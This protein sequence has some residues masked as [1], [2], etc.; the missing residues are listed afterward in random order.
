[1]HKRVLF[2]IVE[3][4]VFNTVAGDA[5]VG[6][7]VWSLLFG[8]VAFIGGLTVNALEK[9]SHVL[10]KSLGWSLLALAIVG[11]VLVPVSGFWLI[12][13][14]AASICLGSPMFVQPEK[15]F[16]GYRL[17]DAAIAIQLTK[18]RL[19]YEQDVQR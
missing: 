13:P 11:V 2:L 17:T 16:Y 5:V 7:I 18:W 3:R 8:V 6:A 9:S 14:P 10:P 19:T 4:G 12:F 15:F 1:V